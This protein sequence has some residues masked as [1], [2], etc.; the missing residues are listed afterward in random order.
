MFDNLPGFHHLST[1][2]ITQ[3]M[4]SRQKRECQLTSIHLQFR[5][6]DASIEKN[7]AT[8]SKPRADVTSALPPPINLTTKP[9]SSHQHSA[10]NTEQ[11]R[12]GDPAL[13]PVYVLP[14]HLNTVQEFV[15]SLGQ[16]L[17]PAPELDCDPFLQPEELNHNSSDGD[18]SSGS[19][20]LVSF[21][22][23]MSTSSLTSS[24]PAA[25]SSGNRA[26]AFSPG[27]SAPASS[28]PSASYVPLAS[29]TSPQCPQTLH[30]SMNRY[31]CILIGKKTGVFWDKW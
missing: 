29:S 30:T 18:M 7:F 9:R 2:F 16:P 5:Y 1:F 28:I 21:F 19:V 12:R 26:S 23:Q 22:S 3:S 24:T 17:F 20:E 14:E 6:L 25:S 10:I 4:S 31:Y 27:F 11:T 8:P 13:V 15:L